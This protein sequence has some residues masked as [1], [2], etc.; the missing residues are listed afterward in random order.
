[1]LIST[2]NKIEMQNLKDVLYESIKLICELES[3]CH[4]DISKKDYI[5]IYIVA[6]AEK[7][8]RL[9]GYCTRTRGK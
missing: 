9:T 7:S 3:E 4:V 6:S 1:L 8:C 2:E 5:Y